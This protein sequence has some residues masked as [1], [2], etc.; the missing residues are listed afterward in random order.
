MTVEGMEKSKLKTLGSSLEPGTS[1]IVA[2]FGEVVVKKSK[3]KAMLKE[4]KEGTD[5]IVKMMGEEISQSLKDG[6][7][8]AYVLAVDEDGIMATKMVKVRTH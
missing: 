8:I 3:H 1:A 5:E 2:V 6:N 4:V 7:D